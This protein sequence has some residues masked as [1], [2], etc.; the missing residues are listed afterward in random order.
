MAEKQQNRDS[1]DIEEQFRSLMEGLRTSLPGVQVLFAFLLTAPLQ[2]GF[3]DLD[4]GDRRAFAVAFISSGIA[5]V[6]LIAPSVHQRARA[7][8][9]GLPR[10]TKS[11]LKWATWLALV[12]SVVMGVALMATVYLVTKLVFSQNP[13]II[14]TAV[15]TAMLL[16]AWFYLPLVTFQRHDD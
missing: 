8:I 11:H 9:S 15:L 14:A 16:W 12:G 7:P 2:Q 10:K 5:S 1:T 6:L 13:A 3:S 4:G